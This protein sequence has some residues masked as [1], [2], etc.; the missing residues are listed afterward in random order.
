[1]V[2]GRPTVYSE[3]IVKKAQEYLKNCNDEELELTKQV[4]DKG[5]TIYD[6]KTKVHLPSIYGLARYL[7]V[8]RDT[9]YEWAKIHQELSDTL[10]EIEAEQAQRLIDNG[11]SGDYNSTIAK[12]MLSSNHGMKEKSDVTT[13]DKDLPNPIYGSKSTDI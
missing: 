8:N 7:N 1:M 12:L 3:E 10:K 11:L 5:Y 9:I 4:G 2:T 13:N 6:Y